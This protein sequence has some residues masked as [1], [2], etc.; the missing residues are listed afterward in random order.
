[1]RWLLCICVVICFFSCEGK[2]EPSGYL[3]KEKAKIID[4]KYAKGFTIQEYSGFYEVTLN[5]PW[6]GQETS[7]K[8]ILYREEMPKGYE[9][10][11]KIKIPIQTIACMSL[12]HIAF[13]S[14]L[15]KENTVIAASGIHYSHNDKFKDRFNK[16]EVKEIGSEQAI[17]YEILVDES[18]DIIMTYGINENSLKYLSKMEKMG[19]TTVLNAEYMENHPLGKAEWIK[20][21]AVFYDELTLAKSIFNTIELEYLSLLE[22]TDTIN[23]KPSVFVGMPWNGSWYV[24]GGKSFQAQL[25]K[26]AGGN[27][28]WSNNDEM[29]SLVKAKEVVFEEAYNADFWLN[30]NSYQSIASILNYDERLSGFKSVKNKKLYNNSKRLN[31]VGGNDYW[32]SATVNPHIVLKDM[33]EIFHPNLLQHKLYYYKQLK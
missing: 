22:L 32:E 12:T 18:P 6:K 9:D 16:G 26:D 2:K 4:V 1:M 24:A 17:N 28:L 10:A 33:I 23:Q 27:Y 25:F 29:S 31:K 19:L 14:E 13:V 21:V 5:D 3:K 7:Y 20:F 11:I 8:Y 15:Q 30:Q